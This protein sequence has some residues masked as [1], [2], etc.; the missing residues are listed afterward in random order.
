M[1]LR[2][3]AAL[4]A[5]AVLIALAGVGGGAR[6]AQA[7]IK[8]LGRLPIPA[9]A[10]VIA[11]CTDPLMQRELNERLRASGLAPAFAA[12][13]RV[14]T[15]T[16]T[17]HRKVMSPGVSLGDIAPGDPAIAGMLEALGVEAPP[18]G[19]SGDAR[20]DPYAIAAHRRATTPS[21]PLSETYRELLA[22]RHTIDR[23]AASTGYEH[24]AKEQIYET[25]MVARAT[26]SSGTGEF[27][28]VALVHPGDDLREALQQVAHEIAAAV[29]S[30]DAQ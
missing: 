7:Q 15:L 21:D 12:G 19:D 5:W 4:I 23:A 28:L 18:L 20:P 8:T 9:G 11:V 6:D 2:R 16:V 24:I 22:E 25:V 10:S 3:R 13:E 26:L 1:E 30:R 27:K 17:V 29:A 14:V